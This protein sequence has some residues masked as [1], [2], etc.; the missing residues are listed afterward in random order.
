VNTNGQLLTVDAQ[1][2]EEP[3]TFL[4]IFQKLKEG[5]QNAQGASVSGNSC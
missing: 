2:A 5:A 1:G 4:D 3:S